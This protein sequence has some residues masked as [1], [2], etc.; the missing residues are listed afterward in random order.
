MKQIK[1]SFYWP[2]PHDN[3][4]SIGCIGTPAST[5]KLSNDKVLYLKE[6]GM[7]AHLLAFIGV[8]IIMAITPG[9]DMALV[10]RA[11]L[12][13]GKLVGWLAALGVFSGLLLWGV[14]SA[15]G[16]A[17]ILNTSATLYTILRLI[18]AAYLVWLGVQAFIS[19][20]AHRAAATQAVATNKFSAYR[21]GLLNNLLNPKA[22]IFFTTLLPQFIGPGQT[23]FLTPILFGAI[24]ALIVMIWLTIYVVIISRAGSFIRRPS[25]QRI[26]ERITGIVLIALGIRVAIEQH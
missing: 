2:L 20:P 17:A 10:T 7:G 1:W 24:F 21:Q 16:V 9:P 8:V 22:G 15:L 26:M 3:T 11:V 6:E 13:S 12:K 23:T 5:V 4:V 19:R 18:G 25:V 14:A